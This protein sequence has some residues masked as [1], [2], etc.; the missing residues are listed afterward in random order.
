MILENAALKAKT[1]QIAQIL[2]AGGIKADELSTAALA[3][4]LVR[5]CVT[6]RV[7]KKQFKQV[8]ADSWRREVALRERVDQLQK[9]AQGEQDS[10][11]EELEGI[12]HENAEVSGGAG[13]GAGSA[14]QD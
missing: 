6:G 3:L 1:Q 10:K 12:S 11:G 2:E 9:E 5:I 13:E 14:P 8:I 4:L 7:N